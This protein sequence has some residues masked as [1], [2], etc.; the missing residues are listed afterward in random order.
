MN[1]RYNSSANDDDDLKDLVMKIDRPGEPALSERDQEVASS[2]GEIKTA[3]ESM[4]ADVDQDADPSADHAEEDDFHSGW[5]SSDAETIG[6]QQL[7]SAGHQ[8]DVQTLTEN[9][10]VPE[11]P[12]VEGAEAA[13]LQAPLAEPAD[14]AAPA[15]SVVV[16]T[17]VTSSA[18]G[19]P[20]GFSLRDDG[21][22][23][24]EGPDGADG[25]IEEKFLCSP[26]RV[27]DRLRTRMGTGWGRRIA[28]TNPE[29]REITVTVLDEELEA[30]GR[31]F[32][33]TLTD[34]GLRIG[35]LKRAREIV[36]DLLRIWNPDKFMMSTNRQGWA[37]DA[38]EAFVLGEGR[39]VGDP[40]VV[41]ASSDV[42]KL[43]NAVC[44][45]RALQDWKQSVAG[46]CVG[47][48]LMTTAVSL[49]FVGPLLEL[50]GRDGGGLHV[51]FHAEVSRVGG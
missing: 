6:R 37:D 51:D 41:L 43:A 44:S 13:A 4:I 35:R 1:L 42:S 33:A 14:P 47:N 50:L 17:A 26:L 19:L 29:G 3:P 12:S 11:A 20:E 30:R 48:S 28:V 5:Q 46:L 8:T 7:E 18:S 45:S 38:C 16:S 27:I 40:D 2:T 24:V 34:V 32:L 23:V 10:L 49:A 9:K 15:S 39:I 25:E 36:L 21:V 22:Y 31:G